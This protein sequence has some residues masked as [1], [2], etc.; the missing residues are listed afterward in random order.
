[1]K[2]Q[3]IVKKKNI[4]IHT[5]SIGTDLSHSHPTPLK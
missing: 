4:K 2:T 3:M 5:Q 1:M